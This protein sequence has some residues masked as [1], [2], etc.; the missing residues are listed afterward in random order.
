MHSCTHSD[1]ITA[2]HFLKSHAGRSYPNILLSASTDGLLCTSNPDEDDEDEAGLHVGNWGCSVA[3]AGWIY[4]K[5]GSPG[6]WSS[7]DMETFGVW[8]SEVYTSHNFDNACI[9]IFYLIQARSNTGC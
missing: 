3:Q 4:G 1:D 8:S 5:T 2:V 6:I 7:S 9:L